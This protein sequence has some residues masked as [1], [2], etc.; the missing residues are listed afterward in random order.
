M[1]SPVFLLIAIFI[2][3]DSKGPILFKQLRVGKDR[4]EFNIYKFRT[5]KVDTP[6][7]IPTWLLEDPNSRITR[8]GKFLRRTS[9]D[10]LPQLFNIIKGEM[11]IIGPRPVIRNE[12]DLFI[13]RDRNGVY[14]INPGL[15]GWAQINGRDVITIKDKAILDGFYAKNISFSF[16]AKIFFLTIFK[17]LKSE[18]VKEGVH[19]G[20]ENTSEFK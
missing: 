15:S 3:L 14:N 19:I 18:G 11:S 8:V 10:E 20:N 17:V 13:E 4:V 1:F 16:D 2:R 12:Y 7:N 6:S 9:L 5:M